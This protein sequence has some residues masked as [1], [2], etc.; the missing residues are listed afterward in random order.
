MRPLTQLAGPTSNLGII[1]DSRKLHEIENEPATALIT[2][3]RQKSA[4]KSNPGTV[5]ITAESI[6]PKKSVDKT[7][8]TDGEPGSDKNHTRNKPPLDDTL[9]TKGSRIPIYQT[10]KRSE[11]KHVQ[12]ETILDKIVKSELSDSDGLKPSESNVALNEDGNIKI[13][14]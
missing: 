4:P 9:Q 13:Q 3:S 10:S 12:S 7:E 14:G 1:V 2:N 5:V 8:S 6:E 11:D